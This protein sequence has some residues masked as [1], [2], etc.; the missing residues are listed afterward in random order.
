MFRGCD[1][2]NRDRAFFLF[3]R[4]RRVCLFFSFIFNTSFDSLLFIVDIIVFCKKLSRSFYFYTVKT[5]ANILHC[6][7]KFIVRVE[8]IRN[9]SCILLLRCVSIVTSTIDTK[10]LLFSSSTP[11]NSLRTFVCCRM[12]SLM[13]CSKM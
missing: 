6:S 3:L 13:R 2:T 7:S 5:M 12:S 11:V 1:R 9:S 4:L 8:I 10:H